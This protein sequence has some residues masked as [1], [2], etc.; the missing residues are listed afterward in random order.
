MPGRIR[1]TVQNGIGRLALDNPPS[2]PM[3]GPFFRELSSCIESI[4]QGAGVDGI[5]VH[6]TGRHF[7][8]GADLDWLLESVRANGVAG[9]RDGVIETNLSTFRSLY[10]LPLPTVA[11]IRGVCIGSGL[12]LALA[13]R[14]RVAAKG[15]VLGLPESTFG[16][17]PGCGGVRMLADLAGMARAMGLAL[18]GN[19][20]SADE[21]LQ[22]GIVDEVVPASRLMERAV[23]LASATV[24]GR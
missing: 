5:V 13:C 6:G 18:T 23:A 16:L 19:T 12:E 22:W 7:S 20:F 14:A 4:L 10:G 11:A 8:S 21:A 2:N 9:E 1:W 17:M 3:D 15:A 24:R